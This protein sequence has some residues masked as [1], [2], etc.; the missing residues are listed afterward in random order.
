LKVLWVCLCLYCQVPA[1]LQEMGSSGSTFPVLWVTAKVTFIA[2]WVPPLSQVFVSFW[3]CP[4]ASPP[5]SV[6]DFHSFS[7]PF[8]YLSCPDPNSLISLPITLPS[9]FPLS[10]CYL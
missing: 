10:I 5:L 2:F 9:Q 1:W 3:R 4:T 7:W 6:A 8:D